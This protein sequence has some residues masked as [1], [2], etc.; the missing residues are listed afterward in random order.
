MNVDLM[1]KI[2]RLAGVPLC[3]LLSVFRGIRRM[4]ARPADRLEQPRRALFIQFAEIGGLVVASPAVSRMR[5]HFPQCEIYFLTFPL[6]D[7]LLELMGVPETHRI[8][9]RKSNPIVFFLDT[10][11]AIRKLRMLRIDTVLS[12]EAF[13]RFS[14]ILAYLSG[15]DRLCGFARF[16]DEGRYTGSL[17]THP[18][19]Y[20]P[21][22]HA[23]RT[24]ISLVEAIAEHSDKLPDPAEPALKKQIADI[25]LALPRVDVSK[26]ECDAVRA[27]LQ[28]LH[29]GLSPAY[30][31][32][33]LNPNSSDMVCARR[34]PGGNFK[35]L[36]QRLLQ[37]E[38]LLIVITGAP[39]EQEPARK[40]VAELADPR[41]VSMAGRTSLRQLVALYSISSLMITNDSGPAH[42]ASL[43]D[44]PVLVLF[45][46]ETPRIYG[47]L[48][49]KVEPHYLG[50]S[51]SPCISAYNQKRSSCTDNVC[52]KS[53]R[54]DDIHARAR[55]LLQGEA[56]HTMKY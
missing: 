29:P 32:V 1:R 22:I 41:V 28:E 33:L 3:M 51:C 6:G 16:H 36:A 54:V 8:V 2:D 43:T 35:E 40:L 48:G 46:P 24:F 53:I 15:A 37:E 20:N 50:I 12:L 56:P 30:R 49:T 9:V 55:A 45:G 52:M 5:S 31:I 23:A 26:Q 7:E 13:A 18:V 21:H 38:Q 39:E 42:F 44:L 17:L 19:L 27:I 4:F 10:L 25:S 14:T 11:A 47:P 34:W